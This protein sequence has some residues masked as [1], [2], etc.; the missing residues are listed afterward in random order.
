METLESTTFRLHLPLERL[1]FLVLGD[2]VRL[3]TGHTPAV[4]RDQQCVK[5][6]KSGRSVEALT[7]C[8]CRQEA[9]LLS[10]GLVFQNFYVADYW[11]L[12]TGI[13]FIF[14]FLVSTIILSSSCSFALEVS[15]DKAIYQ[16]VA[17]PLS[18]REV[19]G[20]TGLEIRHLL[21]WDLNAN[22]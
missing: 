19:I 15:C 7:V 9:L 13:F 16:L 22:E 5:F 12:S 14:I 1:L 11:Y 6:Q 4:D 2:S 17:H 3:S 18:S 20:A 21:L 8:I 10:T